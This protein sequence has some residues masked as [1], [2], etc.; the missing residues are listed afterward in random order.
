MK[1]KSILIAAAVLSIGGVGIASAVAANANIFQPAKVREVVARLDD[2]EEGG[3]IPGN[4][5]YFKIQW[6][7]SWDAGG[8]KKYAAYFFDANDNN[9]WSDFASFVTTVEFDGANYNIQEIKVPEH[10]TGGTWTTVIGGLFS[11]DKTDPSWEAIDKE[12]GDGQSMQSGDIA[13]T[14]T[15]NVLFPSNWNRTWT[16]QDYYSWQDRILDWAATDWTENGDEWNSDTICTT[17]DDYTEA[18]REA[19]IRTSWA[20]SKNAYEAIAGDDVKAKFS[21]YDS[22]GENTELDQLVERYDFLVRKYGL[23]DFASRGI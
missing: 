6:N 1:K 18:D 14:G 22:T 7:T 17:T 23:E 5:I 9:T 8:T 2:Q 11:Q 16:F 3:L 4:A 21:N 13:L 20:N 10:P 15:N 12:N 19:A